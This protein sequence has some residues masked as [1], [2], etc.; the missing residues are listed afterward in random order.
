[1][2]DFRGKTAVVT[3]GA[4]GIG[5]GLAE[6]CAGEGMKVVVA[7]I[8][9]TALKEIETSLRSMGAEVMTV[10]TD[11]SRYDQV[12]EL[13]KRTISAFGGVHLLFNNAG[14]QAGASTRKPVW[15][16]ALED[17][18]WLIG[19]NLMGVVYGIKAFVPVM[20]KQDTDCHIVNTASMAG[21]IS[22]KQLVIYATTKAGVISLSEGLY[23]QLKNA[24]SHIGVSVLCPAFVES[25]IS[26][27]ERNRP[28]AFQTGEA[29]PDEPPSL[30]W[31]ARQSQVRVLSPAES[32]DIV[33]SAIRGEEF[34]IT[35]DPLVNDLFKQRADNILAGKN[36][37]IPRL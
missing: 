21:L 1:M 18:D 34:Y 37:E 27:A 14:V 26:Q 2:K 29:E 22:E 13:M 19:V 36:P 16:N 6:R 4:S 5:R 30:V 9:E 28:A 17:W 35:T 3:G 8:E 31:E 11:V 15:E 32:A 12:Q 33:F 20:L 25:R 23:H 24:G 7:D 10:K